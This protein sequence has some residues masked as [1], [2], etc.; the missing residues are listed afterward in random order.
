MCDSQT[1]RVSLFFHVTLIQANKHLHHRCPVTLF[2]KELPAFMGLMLDDQKH[3]IIS[4]R[5]MDSPSGAS[6]TSGFRPCWLPNVAH[7]RHQESG[8]DFS[9]T[10]TNQNVLQV[11][12]LRW[13]FGPRSVGPA[14]DH[15][16]RFLQT[17]A[18]RGRL[19]CLLVLIASCLLYG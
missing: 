10:N 16:E 11:S 8:R 5:R 13:G 17:P 7:E 3:D 9:E 18:G 2:I 4:V 12:A 19:H 15:P 14:S 1:I 6:Q